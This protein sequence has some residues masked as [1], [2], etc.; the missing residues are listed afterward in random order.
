ML[1]AL[2]L[3]FFEQIMVIGDLRQIGKFEI[4]NTQAESFTNHL[5]NRG[6]DDPE[7]FSRTGRS[8]HHRSSKRIDIHPT[9]FDG[10]LKPE[11]VRN[12]DTG[13]GFYKLLVLI[14]TFLFHIPS[15]FTHFLLHQFG[16]RIRSHLENH[17]SQK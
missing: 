7:R 6:I 12:I 11:Q 10:F 15:V 17:G 9:F 14:E 4:I 2:I 5:T 16:D 3:T 1:V 13:I 8:N